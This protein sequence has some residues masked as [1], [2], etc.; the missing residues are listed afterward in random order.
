[1]SDPKRT[2][3]AEHLEEAADALP[4]LV[5]D[6]TGKLVSGQPQRPEPEPPEPDPDTDPEPSPA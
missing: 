3:I 2:D 6:K 4:D 1:M 5:F